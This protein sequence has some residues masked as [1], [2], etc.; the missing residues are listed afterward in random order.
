MCFPE[1]VPDY[2]LPMDLGYGTDEMDMIGIGRIFDAAPHGPHTVFDMF[3]VF[4]LETDEDDSIPD[5]YTDDMDFIGIG[6]L[7]VVTSDFTSVEGASDSVDPPLSFDTMSGFVTRFDDISDGNNDMSIFEYLNV[8]QHFPLIAPPA[9]TTHIYDVDDVGDTDDPLG[10]QPRE[11]RIGS[12]LSPD[13]RSRLIDLLRSYL[14]VFAWSYEDMPG[15]D[16]TI[17]QHHLPILPHARPVKQ[18]LR[19]LHPRW[20]LQVKEEIQKQLSVGFLSVVE[21]PEWLA[22]VVP[23]PKKDG[24]VRVCVDFRDL[25]KASPKDDFP[26]PHIDMLVDSTAGHPMLSFM[27][28]F[29][30]YNQILMAPEDM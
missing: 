23:V 4:V 18:K 28:G 15:L 10:D 29:S 27:D 2:D 3:G 11:I 17:V 25:N 21:Y 20:S 22:N 12:S 5:A 8:S 6:L 9:P 13:E 26:L 30:G 1:E 14:D 24:K 19:R 7:D 16:P